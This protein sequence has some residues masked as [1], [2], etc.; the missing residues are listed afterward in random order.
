MTSTGLKLF[1]RHELKD[2]N[3]ARQQQQQDGG[4][5]AAAAAEEAQQQEGGGGGDKG[6]CH[7]RIVQE[8]LPFILPHITK[9]AR[10]A[11]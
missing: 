5:D 3:K 8:G 6:Q 11:G 9:Q 1:E 10:G 4:G 2:R 7:Y